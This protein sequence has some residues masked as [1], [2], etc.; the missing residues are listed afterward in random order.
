M[1]KQISG[2]L[3]MLAAFPSLYNVEPI[4]VPLIRAM[5]TCAERPLKVERRSGN[6]NHSDGYSRPSLIITVFL[7]SVPTP[8][9]RLSFLLMLSFLFWWLWW[10]ST[11]VMWGEKRGASFLPQ[12]AGEWTCRPPLWVHSLV[13]LQMDMHPLSSTSTSYCLMNYIC[14]LHVSERWWI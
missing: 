6:R 5:F 14:L 2:S 12:A 3:P 4:T 13:L 1:G 11:P 9:P 8:F 7:A 10:A